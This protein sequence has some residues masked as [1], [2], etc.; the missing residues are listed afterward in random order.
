MI[1]EDQLAALEAD[2]RQVGTQRRRARLRAAARRP[3][4]R[5]RAGHHD[6]RRLPLLL[7]R[8]GASSSSPTRPG[9]EQYTRNM[10]TGA[11]TADLAVILVDARKGVLTQT[12]RHTLPRRRCSA[13]A[14]SCSRSTRWT[15][16]AT[17]EARS[18]AIDA[19]LPRVR[20]RSSASTTSR[21]IPVSALQRRQ[22][23][24]ARAR[25]CPGTTGRRCIELP[26]DASRSTRRD[27]SARRSACRC[28]GS[29]G[30]TSTSAA[31]PARSSAARCARAT[32]VRV[33]PV[34]RARR[35]SRAI[36]TVRRR[37]R[38]GRRRPVGHAHARRRDRRQP[39]RRASPPPT[40]RRG[41]RPVRGDGRLDGRRRRCC[42]GAPTCMQDRHAHGRRR[43]SP[44]LKYKINVNTL[45]HAR[46]D[47]ARAERDR[48]RA[49]SSSTAPIA[50]DPYADNRDTGG[51]ILIDRMTQRDR[52]RR[53]CCTSRCAAS[54][55]VHWQ[56]LDVDK[57]RARAREGP[58]AVRALVHRPVRRRQVDD[59]QPRRA[60]SCTRSAATPTC[61]TATTSATASTRTSASPTPTA[62]R[63]SAAS[64]RSRS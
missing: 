2:S 36:V 41:R 39:R 64:P 59:R 6:R 46:R 58:E 51:F 55:N 49:T 33:L 14:T 16:S 44:P 56:A 40:R 27:R 12:R 31:S 60:A 29:T 45:E 47:A 62:S 38:R 54:Q 30:P 23:R 7:D 18:S 35:A 3:R 53:A 37:P 22:R 21:C 20:R 8:R 26:R 17:R 34:R 19:E 52:R 50:F 57:A 63:T 43:R 4:G 5:A 61:S 24:R 42:A 1:F 10:V 48:R 13:S 32:R 15:W 9:H 28:S 11:S 25:A